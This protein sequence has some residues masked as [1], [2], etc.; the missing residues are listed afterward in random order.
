MDKIQ[1]KSNFDRLPL[2]KKIA[3]QQFEKLN[4]VDPK[5]VTEEVAMI[6]R[7]LCDASFKSTQRDARIEAFASKTN[8][9]PVG[10]YTPRYTQ[11]DAKFRNTMYLPEEENEGF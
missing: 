10:K 6:E 5:A 9:P 11:V 4:K 7:K 2:A 1:K 8:P 3:K